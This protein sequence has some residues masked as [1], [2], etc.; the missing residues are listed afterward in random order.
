VFMD[1]VLDE[2]L[3]TADRVKAHLHAA[4]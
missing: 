3:K 1:D 2:L 4:Q